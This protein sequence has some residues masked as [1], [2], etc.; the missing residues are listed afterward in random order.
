MIQTRRSRNRDRLCME[1]WEAPT[2]SDP[3]RADIELLDHLTPEQTQLNTSMAVKDGKLFVP[4]Y[5]DQMS[6]IDGYM[7]SGLDLVYWSKHA[8]P[9][10]PTSRMRVS[11]AL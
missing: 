3:T 8:V 5:D 4:R 9:P 7:D 6:S 11:L 2:V 1:F 10:V